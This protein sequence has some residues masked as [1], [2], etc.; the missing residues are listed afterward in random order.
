MAVSVAKSTSDGLEVEAYK[1]D[2]TLV[3]FFPC[4]FFQDELGDG[5]NSQQW[6]EWVADN[7]ELVER[8]VTTKNRGGYLN[9]RY[10]SVIA[11]GT[12]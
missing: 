12:K 3:A 10:N 4:E 9:T 11:K 6:L 8:I 5:S 2:G 1:E 7:P